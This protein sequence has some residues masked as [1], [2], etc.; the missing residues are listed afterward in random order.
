MLS[1]KLLRD[2]GSVLLY[3][4]TP[5]KRD[6]APD[7]LAAIADA[8]TARINALQPDAVVLYDIQDEAMRNPAPRPFPFLETVDPLVYGR[9]H[10]QGVVQPK[11]YYRAV[12]KYTEQALR[13]DLASLN[14]DATVFVGAASR[15]A[16]GSLT[17][18]QAYAIH[19]AVNPE[20]LLGGVVIPER[21]QVDRKEHH[22]VVAKTAA[23]CAFFISQCI[24][25]TEILRNFLSDYHYHCKAEGLSPVPIILTVTPCGSAKTLEFMRWLGIGVSHHLENE[26][27][28]STHMLERSVELCFLIAQEILEF[29]RRLGLRVGFNVESVSTRKEEIEAAGRL[30]EEVRGLVG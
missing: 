24:F 3:G 29:A 14:Q 8:Q 4:M 22:R 27:L 26:L 15:L 19:R 12:G 28:Y 2:E 10:L 20:A 23:G 16:P 7:R 13:A 21:H 30:L 1:Q 11:I 6:S 9:H 25:N 18:Q 17:L 5:P